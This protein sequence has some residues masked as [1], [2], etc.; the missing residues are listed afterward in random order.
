MGVGL[1]GSLENYKVLLL[2]NRKE[3][4][5]EIV[6]DFLKISIVFWH[7]KFKKIWYYLGEGGGLNTGLVYKRKD[8]AGHSDSVITW[9]LN[10]L[11][12]N[13]LKFLCVLKEDSALEYVITMITML[14]CFIRG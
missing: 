5:V 6:Y 1:T 8:C 10:V 9:A 7:I 11:C 13:S 3:M 12:T 2:G 4:L 14:F